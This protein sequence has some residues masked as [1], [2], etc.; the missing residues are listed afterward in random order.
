MKMSGIGD[1]NAI[2]LLGLVGGDVTGRGL[3]LPVYSPHLSSDAAGHS[4]CLSE[5]L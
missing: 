3:C 5:A 1:F 2:K 4:V